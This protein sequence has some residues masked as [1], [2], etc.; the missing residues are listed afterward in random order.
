MQTGG[1]QKSENFVDIISGISQREKSEGSVFVNI[2]LGNSSRIVVWSSGYT[3]EER[4]IGK[5]RQV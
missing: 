5:R 2:G 3:G 4:E 1:G